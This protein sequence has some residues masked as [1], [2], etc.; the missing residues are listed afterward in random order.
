VTGNY[1]NTWQYLEGNLQ[2]KIVPVF[3]ILND[4]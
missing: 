4:I 3:N 2:A 1:P